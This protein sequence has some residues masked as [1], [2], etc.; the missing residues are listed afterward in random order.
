MTASLRIALLAP[1]LLTA[2]GDEEQAAVVA[3]LPV[4][5]GAAIDGSEDPRPAAPA[6]PVEE[7]VSIVAGEYTVDATDGG[8]A[9]E[10][11][12]SGDDGPAEPEVASAPAEE[13]EPE[14]EPEGPVDISFRDLSLIDYDVDAMLDL[15]L[16]PE[17]YEGEETA[18]IEVPG[19]IRSLDGREV[20]LVGYMIPGE[21]DRGNVRDFMLVRDLMGCCFGGQPMPDEWV[22]VIMEEEAEAEYRPYMPMRVTGVLTLGGEQDEAG[23]AIGI[24][25]L[26][27][28][29]VQLED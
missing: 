25:R 16:F 2:C 1:I 6:P 5:R 27:A 23:F 20:S 13:P 15:M 21:I 10:A 22:D 3:P 4:V 12:E 14:P 24:Y 17:E 18:D 7:D 8:A 11:S 28:S 19:D 29:E 9:P 26:K